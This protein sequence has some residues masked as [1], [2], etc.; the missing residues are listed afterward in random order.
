MSTGNW[1][2]GYNKSIIIGGTT[3]KVLSSTWA[4]SVEKLVVTHS[5]S[6]GVQGWIPGILDGEGEVTANV[7]ADQVPPDLAIYAGA[8][9]TMLFPLGSAQPFSL[10]ITITRVNYQFA[11]NGLVNYSF[12][13]AM[14]SEVG[15]YVRAT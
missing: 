6:G 8:S 10:P 4:E 3:L 14:N 1:E 9:A 2:P 5:Q 12:N 13:V 11:V 7:D 15:E